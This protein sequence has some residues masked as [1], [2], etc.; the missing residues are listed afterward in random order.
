MYSLRPHAL[1]YDVVC[2]HARY[3]ALL[4]CVCVCMCVCV[5]MY[6]YMYMYMYT[7]THTHTHKHSLRPQYMYSLRPHA[8]VYLQSGSSSAQMHVERQHEALSYT[9][10]EAFSYIYMYI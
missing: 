6:I 3:D 1:V 10:I 2:H 5:I 9:Y 8:L 7:H 4:L